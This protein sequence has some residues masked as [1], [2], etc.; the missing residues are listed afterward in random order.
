MWI[1]T[2]FLLWLI[3]REW[4]SYISKRKAFLTSRGWMTKPQSKVSTD[5]SVLGF[6]RTM[7]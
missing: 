2:L 1:I 4:I 7:G 5:P 6:C 3:R